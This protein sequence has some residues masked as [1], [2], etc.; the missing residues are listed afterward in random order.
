MI[1]VERSVLNPSG[2]PSVV[3]LQCK[4]GLANR[5]R[6]RAAPTDLHLGRAALVKTASENKAASGHSVVDLEPRQDADSILEAVRSN[7]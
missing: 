3:I 4:D 5:P 2:R 1:P 6:G 7:P